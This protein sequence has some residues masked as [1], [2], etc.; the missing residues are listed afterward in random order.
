M[1]ALSTECLSRKADLVL[2]GLDGVN[3]ILFQDVSPRVGY[4]TWWCN[5]A[6]QIYETD[7]QITPGFS[8]TYVTGIALHELGHSLGLVHT[9]T[10][11]AVMNPNVYG[12]TRLHQDDINELSALYP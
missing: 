7:I 5:Q 10:P 6:G 2:I 1:Y 4:S 9:S 8:D 11:G 3:H 12:Y